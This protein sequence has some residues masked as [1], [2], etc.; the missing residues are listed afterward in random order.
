[1][2][3]GVFGVMLCLDGHFTYVIVDDII[4][5]SRS[6]EGLP[7]YGRSTDKDELWVTILEKA[8]FK[9]TCCIE[10]CHGGWM[11]DAIAALMGGVSGRYDPGWKDAEDPENRFFNLLVQTLQRGDIL[12]GVFGPPLHGKWHK[13]SDVVQNDD[14]DAQIPVYD[15]KLGLVYNHAYS[16]LNTVEAHGYQ[17]LCCRNPWAHK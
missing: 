4:G 9:Y 1:M 8:Y 6:H 10:M 15:E 16:L 7:A 11:S 17:L 12:T 13:I 14:P 5:E 2:D 3:V